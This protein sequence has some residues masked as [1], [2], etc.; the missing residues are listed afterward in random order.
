MRTCAPKLFGSLWRFGL[1]E[2]SSCHEK[3]LGNV[4]QSGRRNT[5]LTVP[6]L[7][8]SNERCGRL[9]HGWCGW[10][11]A[12]FDKHGFPELELEVMSLGLVEYFGVGSEE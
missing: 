12:L 4:P 3:S 11:T 9:P 7:Q 8:V 1:N 5:I 10:H 6:C 2:V